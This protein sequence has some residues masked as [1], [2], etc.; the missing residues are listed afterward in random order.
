MPSPRAL[1]ALVLCLLGLL[2]SVTP[3]QAGSQAEVKLIPAVKGYPAGR[4]TP[5]LLL[6]KLPQGM[7]IDLSH[8]AKTFDLNFTG[9]HDIR[10]ADLKVSPASDH[11]GLVV[12]I[13]KMSVSPTAPVGPRTLKGELN[14]LPKSGKRVQVP[15]ALPMD[16]LQAGAS[17]KI[18]S[19]KMFLRLMAGAPAPGDGAYRDAPESPQA[20]RGPAPTA[21][22]ASP[23]PGPAGRTAGDPFSGRSLWF[24][25]AAVF[26]AGLGLNLTPCV[27]PLIP[28]TISFFGGRAQGSRGRLALDAVAYWAGLAL[29]Y[30]LL[31]S[32]AALTGGMLGEA[33]T[34]PAVTV[35]I[36]AVLLIL[37]LSMF[38]LW[39]MRM[40]ASL[41]RLA[42]ASRAG[43]F[44]AFLMGLLL[45]VL[46]AP[47]VGPFVVAIMAHVARVGEM[48]YGFVVFLF[49]A[50]GLGLPLT[51]LALFSG[52]IRKLPGAGDWMIWVR[53]FFG[54]VLVAM[55][56]F[57]LRPVIGES[58]FRW[59]AV[60]VIAAG[61]VHLGFLDRHGAGQGFVTLKRIVGVLGIAAALG[62]W[63]FTTPVVAH[64]EIH[65]QKYSAAAVAEASAAGKPV[66]IDFSAAW[67]P[68][69]RQLEAETFPDPKVIEALS[70][71]VTLRMD[72]T[73]GMSPLA[74]RLAA[75]WKVRGVPTMIF[76]DRRGRWL[77][78]YTVVG[79][80]P[81]G[82]MVNRLQRVLR[83]SGG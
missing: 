15:L 38:G 17:P 63:W 10:L 64:H 45:G 70:G 68:P 40:P 80:I 12:L 67:C 72:V 62:F 14:L 79:F 5:L 78:D 37:A 20:G 48:S 13:L 25:L 30:S 44:G 46:A 8:P 24:V 18:V 61:A 60:T 29:M 73:N 51:V 54:V 82:D 83:A 58:L 43:V 52:S 57:V 47:C 53:R 50:L 7:D 74:R 9:Q 19:R 42:G 77:E 6:L 39:E 28:I 32:L 21:A 27:Y 3:A 36:A 55:A 34:H 4:S 59:L 76:L 69:C 26:I 16:V 23:A 2:L 49:L 11:R 81:P 75:R 22:H 56:V 35:G 65:W 33:L 1:A 71:F 41:N 31:G 66:M